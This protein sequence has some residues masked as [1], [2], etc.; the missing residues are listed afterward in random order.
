MHT[1]CKPEN[2]TGM[3]DSGRLVFPMSGNPLWSRRD[4]GQLRH[5]EKAAAH[6]RCM[7]HVADSKRAYIRRGIF[8]RTGDQSGSDLM[9]G[10]W[11]MNCL[12]CAVGLAISAPL[13]EG[14]GK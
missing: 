12:N 1:L 2:M 3:W 7:R 6:S 13:F 14:S 8:V 4:D 9:H 11:R 5:D 10:G